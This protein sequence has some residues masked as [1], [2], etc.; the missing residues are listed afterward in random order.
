MPQVLFLLFIKYHLPGCESSIRALE[1]Q[2]SEKLMCLGMWKFQVLIIKSKY[3][4]RAPP[5]SLLTRGPSL[6]IKGHEVPLSRT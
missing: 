5:T 1:G 2:L 4:K 3:E 6:W